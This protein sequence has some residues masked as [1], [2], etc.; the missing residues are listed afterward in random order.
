MAEYSLTVNFIFLTTSVHTRNLMLRV[1]LIQSGKINL[2]CHL[3]LQLNLPIEHWLLSSNCLWTGYRSEIIRER[4]PSNKREK[5]MVCVLT[6]HK[7]LKFV[8]IS[9]ELFTQLYLKWLFPSLNKLSPKCASNLPRFNPRGVIVSQG[10]QLSICLVHKWKDGFC[11]RALSALQC[12]A[13][14]FIS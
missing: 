14:V 3:H 4:I 12:L 6:S 8:H 5:I 13:V 7:K 10:L 2:L 11:S 1:T 9:Y